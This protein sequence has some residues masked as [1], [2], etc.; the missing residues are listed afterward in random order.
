MITITPSTIS[1]SS[2][3]ENQPINNEDLRENAARASRT[4]FLTGSLSLLPPP[5][6]YP[7]SSS[8][9]PLSIALFSTKPT[10]SFAAKSTISLQLKEKVRTEFT[11]DFPS[12]TDEHLK[13]VLILVNNRVTSL[14]KHI[15]KTTGLPLKHNT[16]KSLIESLTNNFKIKFSLIKRSEYSKYNIFINKIERTA[17]EYLLG[18]TN[19]GSKN[20]RNKPSATEINGT[21]ALSSSSSTPLSSIS[22]SL[23]PNLHSCASLP[24]CSL[25]LNL[26]LDFSKASSFIKDIKETPSQKE[27]G[28]KMNER[29][30]GFGARFREAF[31]NRY[32]FLA[33]HTFVGICASIFLIDEL[34]KGCNKIQIS[35]GMSTKDLIKNYIQ[36]NCDPDLLLE[37]LPLKKEMFQE[38][39][40]KLWY[41]AI[42]DI[43]A[44]IVTSPKDEQSSTSSSA[45]KRK[46]NEDLDGSPALKQPRVDEED[47]A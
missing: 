15:R 35:M 43:A 47:S 12:N 44:D 38:S 2:S 10:S 41:E 11:A 1:H 13:K 37:Q 17:K 33:D 34:V 32:F 46:A 28:A 30:H 20:Q 23:T 42:V 36:T 25:P 22:S 26:D 8:A 21:E 16:D 18:K 14:K 5:C 7:I 19:K 3:R 6:C 9:P 40:V 45:R 4:A 29:L 27:Q 39:Q 31:S 24:L